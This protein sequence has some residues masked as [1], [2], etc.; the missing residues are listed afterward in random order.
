M[1]HALSI[2]MFLIQ[3]F[4]NSVGK[5]GDSDG[6]HSDLRT[7]IHLLS[8]VKK[9]LY[10]KSYAENA[11]ESKPKAQLPDP[12]SA[13]SVNSREHSC[14][15]NETFFDVPITVYLKNSK[16]PRPWVPP[17]DWNIA[18]NALHRWQRAH[19]EAMAELKH[20]KLGGLELRVF[21]QQ[22]VDHLK[23]LRFKL[24]CGA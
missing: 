10:L 11:L 2:D 21:G 17:K 14:A 6:N 13:L 16:Q 3:L 1:H 15:E 24:F 18:Y 9:L 7:E 8:K 4:F 12:D 23:K 19:E 5:S 20:S 22:Q